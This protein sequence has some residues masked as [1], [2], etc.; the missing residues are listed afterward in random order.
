MDG[1]SAANAG[2]N[3]RPRSALHF[4]QR[5]AEETLDAVELDDQRITFAVLVLPLLVHMGGLVDALARGLALINASLATKNHEIATVGPKV[6]IDQRHGGILLHA[7]ENRPVRHADP[8]RQR[9]IAVGLRAAAKRELGRAVLDIRDHDRLPA[10]ERR[11][12]GLFHLVGQLELGQNGGRGTHRMT[13]Y[14]WRVGY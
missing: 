6:A 1:G 13:P 5:T 7:V 4:Q 11:V 14:D 3:L 10:L 2:A 8:D 9:R 12:D